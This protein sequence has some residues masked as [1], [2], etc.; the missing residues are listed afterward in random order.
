MIDRQIVRQI[1]R[2][3]FSNY[4]EPR[5][6]LRDVRRPHGISIARRPRK[7]GKVAVRYNPLRQN[8]A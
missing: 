6:R 4:V 7:R 8:P 2:L 5:W 1:A 3:D